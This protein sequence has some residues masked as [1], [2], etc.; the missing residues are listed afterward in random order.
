MSAPKI[1]YVMPTHNRVEWFP[2]CLESL[3]VQEGVAPEDIEVIA[4][5]DGSTDGTWELLT[6]FAKRD[7]RIKIIRNVMNM[8]GGL[9]RNIGARN[10]SADIL[11]ICDD[12][13]IYFQDRTR[14]ILK[15]FDENPGM[16]LV[17][18]P[19]VRVGF[20]DE[21]LEIFHGEAF[22]EEEFKNTGSVNYF[23]NPTAAVRKADYFAM[24]GYALETKGMTDDHQFLT[25]WVKSGR[26]VGFVPNEYTCGHRV[27]PESMMAKMRGFKPEWA[28][29]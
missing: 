26:K 6:W 28:G 17:N 23:C 20:N 25:N 19:Y 27:L 18:F 13:D 15:Y 12:D 10:A 16:A 5:D 24:G 29:K 7:P 9:S 8:G 1:S 4:V 14:L 3:F 21:Q 11:G 2:T 22:K